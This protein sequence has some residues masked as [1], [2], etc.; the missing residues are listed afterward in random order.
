MNRNWLY[1]GILVILCVVAYFTLIRDNSS[2][3]SKKDAAFAIADTNDIYRIV[4]TNM[5]G[6]TI[7]LKRNQ[8]D[9]LVND[10]YAPRPDA[11]H[12]LLRT[13]NQMAVKVPVSKSMHNN[14]IRNISG[15]HT[16]VQIFDAKNKLIRGYYIGDN[17]DQLNGTFM[18]ME[19]A[20]M[21]FVVNIPGFQGYISSVFFTDITDWRSKEIF[22]YS[23]AE[24]QQ[25]DVTYP[26]VKD[27][28]FSLV[29]Q[30]N[31][32][33]LIVANKQENKPI[34]Q[35][36]VQFYLKQFARLNAEY[37][38]NEP[39]KRDS[40]LGGQPACLMS[41]TDIQK[42]TTTLK[43][44]YRPV[45][46]RSKAQ[47]TY[48]DKPLQFDPDKF[49]GI[50]HGD[51]DLAIIQNFVFGKVLVGPGFFYRQRPGG[52]NMLNEQTK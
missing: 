18:L 16:H 17:T 36:I 35:E 19:E 26:A 8:D 37:Y 44:Y 10:L 28:T 21:P 4:L 20:D 25:I 1:F 32:S 51:K 43:I 49:Y 12:N 23:T 48:D 27:S 38:I 31:G 24:I 34:N 13:M 2:S 15:R 42:R 47:F 39:D 41:V 6:D 30:Q 50:F 29:K 22:A 52:S 46:V 33:F 11:M 3:Y 14:V 5:K 7:D 9:W 45:T 40:L